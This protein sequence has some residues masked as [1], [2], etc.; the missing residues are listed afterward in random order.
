[1][2][3]CCNLSLA[4]SVSQE[5][6]IGNIPNLLKEHF[7]YGVVGNYIK[8]LTA[9]IGYV[10]LFNTLYQMLFV[11]LLITLRVLIFVR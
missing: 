7:I 10:H 5:I 6:L 9:H 3:I 8:D 4:I 1:V 2:D 11:Y